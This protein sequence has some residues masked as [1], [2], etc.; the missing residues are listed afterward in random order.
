MS[1]KAKPYSV[2]QTIIVGLVVATGFALLSLMFLYMQ[3]QNSAHRIAGKV[4][5][6]S[7]GQLEIQNARGDVTVLNVAPDAELH[8]MT[9]LEALNVGQHIMSRGSFTED[10]EFEV[11]RMRVIRSPKPR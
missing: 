9:S 5:A 3:A 8:G 7:E 2:K 1:R 11:D 4:I 10:R 6:I